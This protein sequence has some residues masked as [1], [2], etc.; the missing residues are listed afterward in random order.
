MLDDNL[1]LTPLEF[2]EWGNPKEKEYFD[3]I[4][5][6]SPYDNIK[7]QAYPHMFIVSGV[8]DSRVTYWEPLK[9][10]AKLRQHNIGN[11]L[12]MMKMYMES[13]HAG[14]SGKYKSLEEKATI[15]N[16]IINIL[17]PLLQR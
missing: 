5:S 15:Y 9:W 1:P 3:Y 14:G 8:N 10:I 7:T 12:L 16:F 2:V 17:M 11:N 13:G 6:Y 4:S